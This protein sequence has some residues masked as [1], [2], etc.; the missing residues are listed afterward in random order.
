[1]RKV[2]PLLL[3]F[4]AGFSWSQQRVLPLGSSFKDAA[5]APTAS[6][7]NGPSVFPISEKDAGVYPL[8]QDS[9]KRYSTFGYFL[10]Q[11]QL[12]EIKDSS[13]AIWITPL[14]DF[15]YG[16]QLNDSNS[17]IY[18]N[19]RG[20][21]LEGTFGKRIFYTTSFYE[22]QSLFPQYI[23]DY[24][25]QRGEQ[26]P[27]AID[28]AYHTQNAVIPGAARTKPFKTDGFDYAYAT[29]MLTF[30]VTPKW[31]VWWGNQP[32]F[33]G[34]GHRSLL[35]SDNSVAMMNLRMR[36]RFSDKWDLQFVR[37]R[38]LNL[39][40]RPVATNGEAYYEPKS[41]SIATLYF[42]P[43]DKISIG[44]FEGGMW[45]RG[46]SVS[47]KSIPALY[48]LPAPGAAAIQQAGD[49]SS[50]YALLGLDVRAF[51]GKHLVY[52]QF[53]LNP[54][55]NNSL[56]YQLGV[57]FFPAKH[58][59]IQL[60]AEYNHADARAYTA[61]VSR[62]N[63]GNYNLPV[64]HPAGNAFDELLLRLNCE[65]RH[66]FAALQTNY[67]LEKSL[68]ATLLMPVVI[69]TV[70]GSQQVLHQSLELGYRF[71]RTYGLEAFCGF[72]YRYASGPAT[73]NDSWI[74]A[75]IRTRLINH[76]FD[77]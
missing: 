25:S 46:D 22:N 11:R 29:G 1:M 68:D 76:Y 38:G 20:V 35:W 16:T 62:M 18:Q 2:L 13:Y 42:Q 8:L 40:R 14:F 49:D 50:A 10:Y 48:F 65:Y 47:Q 15:S 45:Y 5:F 67:Y 69:T 39:L 56:V 66:W 4:T 64:A 54:A 57:R 73:E 44:L 53:G 6:R 12:I 31:T 33:I 74:S 7:L 77:F 37:A 60:Q 3:L 32:L 30:F 52:G 72:R 59:F 34:S 70:T 26:Y 36:Y 63:Y 17:R 51:I 19:T 24:V 23:T 41:M 9:A 21:R 61:T 71:N 58:P 43:T 75:G 28:S 27:S 55:E